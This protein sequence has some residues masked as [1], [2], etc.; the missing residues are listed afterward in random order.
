[1][2]DF[3]KNADLD[4]KYNGY[5][6]YK[7]KSCL[8]QLISS[9]VDVAEIRYISHL[10][11]NRL[12][13]SKLAASDRN[14]DEKIRMNFWGYVKYIF[15]KSAVKLPSFDLSTCIDFFPKFFCSLNT[16]KNFQIPDSIPSLPFP[17]S[18]FDLSPP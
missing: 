10:P 13:K 17:T 8:K 5:S 2:V 18:S 3:T 7:L 9:G 14:D 4:N 16:T 15:K 1:M 11:R 6:N 12:S